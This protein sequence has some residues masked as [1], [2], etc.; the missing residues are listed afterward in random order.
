PNGVDPEMFPPAINARDLRRKLGLEG[1]TVIGFIGTFGPWH[2]TE[3]LV[4]AFANLL[5]MSAHR[6]DDLRL[7]MMGQGA[8]HAATVDKAT[9]LGVAS[10]CVFTGQVSQKEAPQYLAC[11]D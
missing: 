1:K 4:E 2:G 8:R 6:R 5:A 3:Q 7:L 10:C 11:C 9:K